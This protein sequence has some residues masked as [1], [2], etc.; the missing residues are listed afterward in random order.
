MDEGAAPAARGDGETRRSALK[1]G[2]FGGALLVA[3]GTAAIALRPTRVRRPAP[4]GLRVFTSAEYAVFAAMA[5]RVVAV[6]EGALSTDS[7]DVALRADRTLAMAYPSV[8]KEMKQLLGL[9]ENG[10][11]GVLTGTGLAPFTASSRAKKDARLAAWAA[12]RVPL[13]RTGYQAMKRLAHACYYSA[14]ETWRSVGYPGPMALAA[15][16]S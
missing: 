2:L 1:K 7:V 6:P 15:G 14:P 12:S 9:F 13:F 5:E 11:T 4:S 3:A 8:Q 16:P 10:L